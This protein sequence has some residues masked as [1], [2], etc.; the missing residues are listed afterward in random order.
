M[1]CI[2]ACGAQ[3]SGAVVAFNE[4]WVREAPPG[5]SMNAAYGE[6]DNTGGQIVEITSFTSEQYG[7][8]SLHETVHSDGKSRMRAVPVLSLAPGEAVQLEPGGMHLMLSRP[9]AEYRQ[10]ATVGIRAH[11][12]AGETFSFQLEVERR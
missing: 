1:L 5:A 8:V 12:V 10:G 6:L 11:G 2:I 9:D 7:S 3:R 4:A